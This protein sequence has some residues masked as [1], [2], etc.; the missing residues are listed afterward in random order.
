MLYHCLETQASQPEQLN[1]AVKQIA[2]DTPF[3]IS[4]SQ[5]RSPLKK[6]KKPKKRE[7]VSL[8]LTKV[9]VEVKYSFWNG[10]EVEKPHVSI[11]LCTQ[12]RNHK[13]VENGNGQQ[14]GIWSVGTAGGNDPAGS[15]W[16]QSHLHCAYML[17]PETNAWKLVHYK[18]P[19]D[20]A[21][22]LSKLLGTTQAIL[23]AAYTI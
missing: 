23:H 14:R 12:W 5:R 19:F 11:V 8:H 20:S 6:K 10:G 21:R 3:F 9:T 13:G 1:R 15:S 18:P 4:A 17:N 7:V 22:N 16:S 2:P